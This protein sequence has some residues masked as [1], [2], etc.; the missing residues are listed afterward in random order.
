MEKSKDK[1]TMELDCPDFYQ[2]DSDED[3][4]TEEPTSYLVIYSY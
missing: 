1:E 4:W 3:F 2:Q